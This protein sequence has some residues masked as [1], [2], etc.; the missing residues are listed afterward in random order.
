MNY[1]VI[2]YSQKHKNQ[3]D[4]F[5]RTAK[6]ATFLFYRDFMEYHSDRFED[7]S[8]MVFKEDKLVS[9]IPANRNES[10]LYSHQGLT[11]GGLVILPKLKLTSFI[12][13]FKSVL[14]FL[15]KEGIAYFELKQLPSFF[16]S[17]A[18]DEI[19]YALFC[20]EAECFR[21]ETFAV[22]DLQKPYHFSKDRK[23][24][25]KRGIKNNLEVKEEFDLVPFWEKLLIPVLEDKHEAKPVHSAEEIQ[26]LKEKFPNQIRQ[27]NVYDKNKLVAGTTIFETPLVAHSQYIAANSDKNNNGSLDFLHNHLIKN[28]FP[29]KAFFDFGTFN[30]EQGTKINSGLGYWKQ[31]FGA[32]IYTQNFY[33]I[34]T[35]NHSKLNHV[36]Q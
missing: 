28:V 33:R 21:C 2:R 8:L 7:H 22:L 3:W 35:K 29:K 15:E 23:E 16:A 5:V 17:F 6:N 11:Y 27:F 34:E 13:I 14:Q 36:C 4:D 18:S 31:S 12:E 32:Q 25:F 20:V 26:K 24:G 30:L 9:V 19:N 10:G 1:N